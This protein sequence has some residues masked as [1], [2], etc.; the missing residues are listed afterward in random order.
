MNIYLF[1]ILAIL[2]GE[3][4]L[5]LIVDTANI[6]HAAKALPKE[7]EGWYPQ[8]QYQR[9][10]EYL[11][12]NTRFKLVTGAIYTTV[13]VIFILLG[14]FN[15]VD[16]AARSAGFGPIVTGLIFAG[17]L[18]ILSQLL[19]L[20]V[21][22]Y[23]TFV[24]EEKFGFNRTTVRTF[25]LDFIKGLLLT[26]VI[27][28]PIL[29]LI[30]WLFHWAGNAAWLYC[31][32]AVTLFEIFIMFIA[33]AV[34]LPMFNKFTPLEAGDLRTAI[35]EYAQQENFQ[36][37]GIYVMDGSRR[38]AKS[39]A[40]FTGF[41]RFRKIALF[42]TLIQRHTIQELVS[43]LAHEIGH[44]KKKHIIKNLI[45][46]IVTTGFMFY[47]LSFFIRN[48][49]LFQAFKMEHLSVYAS[50]V[51]FGFLY[52]PISLFIAILT[53]VLSRRYEY[54][55]DRFAVSTYRHPESF[56]NALKKLSV[57]NLSNLTPH[58]WKVFL[59]YTHPP[60][61]KRIEAIREDKDF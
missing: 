56:I 17:I 49:G 58:P 7:F 29:A 5:T 20:P 3:Y 54:Q 28:I 6:R 19:N 22:A 37:G 13:T 14:G 53:N 50:L 45:L 30:I 9:S 1:I 47:L 51:F 38:S 11:N 12:V 8:E 40:F 61:L 33:P 10:Q 44:Y 34:I 60:V 35:E 18:F 25:L 24:I 48:P 43:V 26:A 32:A 41:G 21:S 4:L 31:W 55:A 2:L 36:L 16:L 52:T 39:N 46:S 57:D 27:G 42:D 59:S 23:H 15:H